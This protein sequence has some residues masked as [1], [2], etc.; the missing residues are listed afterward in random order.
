VNTG[1]RDDPGTDSW[2]STSVINAPFSRGF[3]TAVWSGTQMIVWGG[4]DDFNFT[5]TGGR[6]CAQ[7]GPTPTPT[8]SP[9]PTPTPAPIRVTVA[10]APTQINEGQS[11]TY[12]VTA[13]STVT[14]SITVNYT[15]S[16]TATNGIDYS[17]TGTQGQVTVSAGQS[18]AK[19]GMKTNADHLTEGTETAIMTLQPGSGYK[20]GNPKQATVSI[21]DSP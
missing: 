20:L 18:S 7:G 3:H 1:G 19:I 13:S 11:S 21:L 6:Y 2:T 12:T 4:A 17:L 8:P 15:M 5:N 10:A 14:Q 9:T 16:G